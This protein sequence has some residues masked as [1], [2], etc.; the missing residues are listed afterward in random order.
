MKRTTVYLGDTELA[1]LESEK[2]RTGIGKSEFIRRLIN[3]FVAPL[4]QESFVNTLKKKDYDN[5]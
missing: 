2:R 5:L 3:K 1:V 4:P